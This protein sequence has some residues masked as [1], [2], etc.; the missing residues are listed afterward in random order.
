[1]PAKKF[2]FDSGPIPSTDIIYISD[3]CDDW[4]VV[5]TTA[6]KREFFRVQFRGQQWVPQPSAA[7]AVYS[8][9]RL[10]AERAEDRAQADRERMVNMR[11]ITGNYSPKKL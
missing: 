11:K 6:G 4:R 10:A 3:E 5:R 7:A 1:M 9:D 8:C 2:R